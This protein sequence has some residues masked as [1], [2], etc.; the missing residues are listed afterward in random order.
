MNDHR[1][2]PMILDHERSGFLAE[3]SSVGDT[4]RMVSGATGSSGVPVEAV[5][6]TAPGAVPTYPRLTAIAAVGANGVIGDG[7][8]MLC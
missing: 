3:Q 8:G 5:S 4:G 2:T 7:S 1:V 6:R